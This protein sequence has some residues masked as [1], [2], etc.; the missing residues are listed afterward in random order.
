MIQVFR[1]ARKRPVK[2]IF[3]G[4]GARKFG[5]RWNNPGYRIVYTSKTI[6]LCV[7]EILVNADFEEQPED[8]VCFT[9]RIPK[10]VGVIKIKRRDLKQGWNSFPYSSLTRN[11]G[12]KWIK[13]KKSAVL[14]VPSVV[15]PDENNYLLN[16]DHK[17]F[18]KIKLEELYPIRLDSRLIK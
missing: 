10:S 2:D 15:V 14:C 6:S 7:L 11:T 5:G 9:A 16:P 1:V 17:D 18:K 13:E 12:E 3:N 8:L 4:M